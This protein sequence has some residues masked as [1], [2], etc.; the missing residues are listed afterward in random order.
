MQS[1]EDRKYYLKREVQE[2]QAA[3]RAAEGAGDIH[4]NLADRY[5]ALAKPATKRRKKSL[6]A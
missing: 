2:R 6:M 4:T 5:A 1:D 3:G